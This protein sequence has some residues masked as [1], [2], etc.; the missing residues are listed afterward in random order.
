MS[1]QR[2]IF[3]IIYVI[4]CLE[5]GKCA[6]LRCP[7]DDSINI[8]DG[9][10]NINS[11]II[12]RNII[13]PPSFY[14]NVEYEYLNF[15]QK[16][17]T[18]PYIRGCLCELKPCIRLCCPEGKVFLQSIGCTEASNDT[19][20]TIVINATI[21]N[22]KRE[23]LG[24][25]MSDLMESDRFGFIYGKPCRTMFSFD[26]SHS[27]EDEWHLIEVSVDIPISFIF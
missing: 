24:L 5:C 26:P 12:H 20:I 4:L 16:V 25:Q 8:T 18:K 27:S 6:K 23:D 14:D 9:I 17:R 19:S 7:Y 2:I 11:N 13:Y 15:S 10:K 21:L 22:H 1:K 3:M